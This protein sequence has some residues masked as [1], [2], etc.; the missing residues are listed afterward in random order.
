MRILLIAALLLPLLAFA[1][2]TTRASF[3][4]DGVT[5]AKQQ[6]DCVTKAA[7]FTED[8]DSGRSV[9][10]TPFWVSWIWPVGWWLLYYGLALVIGGYVYRDAKKRE[11]LVLGIRPLWRLVLV[12]FDPALGVFAYWAAHYSKIAQSFAEATAQAAKT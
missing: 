3:I 8:R 7:L 1:S 4:C 11:W 6:H 12:L 10:E 2:E 9:K 5:D